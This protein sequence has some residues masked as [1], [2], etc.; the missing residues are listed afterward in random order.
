MKFSIIFLTLF[1]TLSISA[2]EYNVYQDYYGK[3]RIS[4]NGIDIAV[5]ESEKGVECKVYKDYY[6]KYRLLFNK[7]DLTVDRIVKFDTNGNN[8]FDIVATHNLP[9]DEFLKIREALI[10]FG[11]CKD[12]PISAI[13]AL[14]LVSNLSTKLNSRSSENHQNI[15]NSSKDK[16]VQNTETSPKTQGSNSLSK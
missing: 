4:S 15:F 7:K 9:L 1:S 12:T 13:E 14:N 6:N 11:T 16:V 10:E 2:A 3:T 8:D 5:L